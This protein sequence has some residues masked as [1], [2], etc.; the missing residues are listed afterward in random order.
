MPAE[1][2]EFKTELKQLLHLIT[3]SLY[4]NREIFLRELI[5]NASDA[6]NKIKFDSLAHEERL[7]GNKDWKIKL[8]PN[9]EG[10]TLT[11]SDNGIGM[12]RDTIVDHLGTIAKSGTKAFLESVRQQDGSIRPDLIG[13]FGVGFY[14][15]FMVADKVT[16]I[17]RMAGAPADGVKWESAGQGEFS[18]EPH[19]KAT[20]GTDV[21]L[22]LKEDAKEYLEPWT[23]R[24]LVKRYS[25][26]I[27]HPVV[28]DVEKTEDDKKEVTEETLNA[29]TALWLRNKSDVKPEEY[30]HFYEQISNDNEKPARV[31]H[32]TAEG[33]TEFKVLAFIPARKPFSLTWE[34]PKGL[35]L[36]IQRVLIMESCEELLPPYLR[37]VRGV[38]DS[39]DLPLNI[40]RELLQQNPLL[41][42]I[43][44]N[45][46][47]NVLEA[48]E[49]LKNTEY[50][51]YVTFFE[52]L[53]MMLKEGAARDWANREAVLN[54]LLFQSTKTEAGKFT[55]L[56]DYVSRMPEG[57]K[58][59][60]YLIGETREIIESSPLLE[61]FKSKGY[62]VLLLTDP[63]DEFLMPSVPSYKEKPLKPV[64]RGDT[65]VPAEEPAENA[66]Q[67]TAFLAALKV[68]LPDVSDVR[69]SK[70]LKES[71]SVLVAD[72]QAMS[73]HYERLMKKMG[74]LEE[75]SKRAL[76]INPAHP[77]VTALKAAFEKDPA[78]PRVES[79]GRL[80]YEQA[81][82]A[83]GSK[84]KDPAGFARRV[85]ELM[86]KTLG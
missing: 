76:E 17:S 61:A 74:R 8:T 50:D 38:V 72:K 45:V 60:Y 25:D 66:E 41:E 85:N 2:L 62:E 30:D 11:I 1:T 77:A 32:Y 20:R 59:I 35:K 15:A 48:L 47:R 78:D 56:A 44:K 19:E 36:Y 12:N 79:Y 10:M 54:L 33:K 3:H 5:S 39:A 49:A 84:L 4:S 37:F 26:F 9:Q 51:K 71:A 7:E 29:Q 75:E 42:R 81:V 70:R 53:G 14:S 31:I 83:E 46:V 6:I 34:E 22:H 27:E 68:R 57:Q 13:Q 43:Q 80:L 52:D 73:A 18:V 23:L 64:D 40:S 82:I 69:L 16:V 58:D 21:I 67:F 28:M 55:T 63:I 86:A 24:S 65:D